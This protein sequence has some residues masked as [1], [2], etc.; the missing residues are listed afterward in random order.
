M[1]VTGQIK[2]QYSNSGT[3]GWDCT[4]LKIPVETKSCLPLLLPRKKGLK[5]TDGK[6]LRNRTFQILSEGEYP[7]KDNRKSCS[8]VIRSFIISHSCIRMK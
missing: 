4:K 3:V 1:E 2:G 6:C 5:S 8:T 7:D